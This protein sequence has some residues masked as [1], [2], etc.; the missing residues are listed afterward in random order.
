[1][2]ILEPTTSLKERMMPNSKSAQKLYSS[3]S[4]RHKAAAAKTLMG[5]LLHY[6]SDATETLS[7]RLKYDTLG[8]TASDGHVYD[9]DTVIDAMLRFL[10]DVARSAVLEGIHIGKD[11]RPFFLGLVATD[12]CV[13][14]EDG[15]YGLLFPSTGV[16]ATDL[17][18]V[19]WQIAVLR[20]KLRQVACATMQDIQSF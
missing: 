6:K 3:M 20:D 8:G 4:C 1:M 14:N 2:L 11:I 7:Y 5:I 9:D 17:S 16:K 15:I 18:A 19:E 10:A 13:Y 12:V